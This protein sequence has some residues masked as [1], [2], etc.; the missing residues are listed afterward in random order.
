LFK[1][2]LSANVSKNVSVSAS[3]RLGLGLV[4]DLKL[5][6]LGLVSVSAKCGMVSVS[7]SSRT[8]SQTSRSR[9]G[10]GPQGLVYIPGTCHYVWLPSFLLFS[11]RNLGGRRSV[12]RPIATKLSLVL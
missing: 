7:V 9:L 5:E 11:A 1:V 6:G 10:L 8:E 3:Q 4:S 2:T 12:P